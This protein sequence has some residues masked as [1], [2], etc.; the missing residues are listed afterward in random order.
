VVRLIRNPA[1]FPAVTSPRGSVPSLTVSVKRSLKIN[2]LFYPALI[3][4]LST[5]RTPAV[6]GLLA[7]SA[8][9]MSP[10]GMTALRALRTV[11]YVAV[12]HRSMVEQ[13]ERPSGPYLLDDFRVHVERDERD[14]STRIESEDRGY[15]GDRWWMQQVDPSKST[16]VA[17]GRTGAIVDAAGKQFYAGRGAGT[18]L[19]WQIAYTRAYAEST[20]LGAW[21]DDPTATTF[22]EW[23]LE[24]NGLHYP[25]EWTTQQLD[26]PDTVTSIVQ[27]H[28]DAAIANADLHIDDDIRAAHP[29][30][31]PLAAVPFRGP[32]PEPSS[33][34][35]EIEQ[36]PYSWDV[37]FVEQSDGVVVIECPISP[38]YTKQAFAYSRRRYGKP[39]KAVITTSDSWPHIAGVRQAAAEGVPIY[40]LDLNVP[41]LEPMLAAPHTQLPDDLAQA[42]RPADIRP[43][44]NITSIGSGDTQILFHTHASSTRAIFFRRTA[45]A[46]GLRRSISRK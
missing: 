7:A 22:T 12:G 28:F 24:P 18:M 16:L 1:K 9:A 30:I 33:I 20:F 14:G 46:A 11:D 10:G 26:L 21:G 2:A 3:G 41:I 38:A 32:S 13:S 37:E 34:A 39:V 6:H 27:L 19:P 15:A 42:P 31:P 23:N 25:R 43:V 35:P 17:D 44:S 29:T 5:S 8:Q 45:S 36:V 4:A 40:A